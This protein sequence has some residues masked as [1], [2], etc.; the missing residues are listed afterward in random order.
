LQ[1]HRAETFKLS[2]FRLYDNYYP[3]NLV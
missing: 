3:G 2:S 1:P